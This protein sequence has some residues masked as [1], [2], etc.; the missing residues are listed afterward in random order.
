MC[1][2]EGVLQGEGANC[3]MTGSLRSTGSSRRE[4]GALQVMVESSLSEEEKGNLARLCAE[5][6][7]RLCE[8]R[9]SNGPD[10]SQSSVD[11]NE[12]EQVLELYQQVRATSER[13]RALR[14]DVPLE[15]AA[16]MARELADARPDF[17]V[18]SAP[19]PGAATPGMF[20]RTSS[21]IPCS[22]IALQR[23]MSG[24]LSG[25]Q[26][27]QH[28]DNE[29]WRQLDEMT[30]KVPSLMARL[31]QTL[32]RLSR[33]VSITESEASRPSPRTVEKVMM[34]HHFGDADTDAASDDQM[35]ADATRRALAQQ[36][37]A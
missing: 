7:A 2:G 20:C 35:G 31:D 36:L 28:A 34:A 32:Q 14:T 16:A 8:L 37:A 4:K 30:V 15:L 33:I 26:L 10:D 22:P 3:L 17:P 5:S 21:S 27:V 19:A 25:G 13:V 24:S 11:T 6:S 12:A 23:A 9:A 18:A 29:S 1:C